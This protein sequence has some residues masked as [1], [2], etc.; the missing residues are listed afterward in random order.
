MILLYSILQ[1]ILL[2][3]LFLPILAILL[4]VPKYRGRA[5]PRLGFGISRG[6]YKKHKKRIWIHALSVGEVTSALPLV[7]GIQH[8]M[9]EVEIV[10]SAAT[11]AGAALAEKLLQDEVVHFIPFPFDLLPVCRHFISIIQPDLF[12]L[13]ETDF[14]P[15]MLAALKHKNVPALLVNGRISKQ[16]MASYQR[17]SFLFRPL[18]TSF[19]TLAM[20][21]DKDKKMLESLGVETEQIV[22]LGNLKYDT[23]LYAHS[24]RNQALSF[25]LPQ[26]QQLLV[27]GSTHEGEE[28]IILKSFSEIKKQHPHT[29]LIIAPRNVHRG[30][31]IREIAARFDLQG[32]CR[33]QINVGG[34]DLLIL[35]TIGELNRAYSHA[36]IAFVG[37][38]LVAQG[39]HNPIEPAIFRVPVLFGIHMEDFSEVSYQLQKAGGAITIQNQEGM[40]RITSSLLHNVAFREKTGN[41]AHDFIKGKQ[42]VVKSHITLIKEML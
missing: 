4:F 31:A 10:F 40:T 16:S 5:L 42:G 23:A 20:Q 26:Y 1:L 25:C 22:T 39:G 41:A 27:A 36:H 18:F 33:S 24:S 32:N 28:E 38:S 30:N 9:P 14:W 35:D 6:K 3:L 17:F 34:R 8:E 11:R 2:P 12:I 13:V 37:G 7:S 15:G 29:Y 21:T 19:K